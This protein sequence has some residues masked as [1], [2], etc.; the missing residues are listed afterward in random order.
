MTHSHIISSL[1]LFFSC[2]LVVL[3]MFFFFFLVRAIRVVPMVRV[4]RG[5]PPGG[6]HSEI[7][8]NVSLVVLSVF[9]SILLEVQ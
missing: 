1:I 7:V 8:M 4:I 9:R 3:F 2:S 5:R 6:S